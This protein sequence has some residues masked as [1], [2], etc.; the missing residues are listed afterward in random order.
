MKLNFIYLSDDPNHVS[1]FGGEAL[2]VLGLD[3]M[4]H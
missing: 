1:G 3:I 4:P 2:N